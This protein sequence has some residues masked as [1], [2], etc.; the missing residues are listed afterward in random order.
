VHVTG[1]EFDLAWRG[2]EQ[3]LDLHLRKGSVVVEGPLAAGGVK[4]DAGQRL[5]ANTKLG[6]LSLVDELNVPSVEAP[7]SSAASTRTA[8]PAGAAQASPSRVALTPPA[9]VVL[10]VEDPT[11]TA[12]VAHGEFDAVIEDAERRGF[13]KA[14]AE[15][16]A[17]DLAA[18]G[19]AARYARRH[20]VAKR[21]LM[22]ER[23]RYPDSVQARDA[24]FFLG[25]IAEAEKNDAASVEWYEIYLRESPNGEYAS[26]A[27][28]RKMVLAQR[29]RDIQGAR[30]IATTYLARFPD[31]P[32]ASP[33][34]KL[35]QAQ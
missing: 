25:S 11:W 34:R 31:G 3:T 1:T 21:A 6:S 7:S 14:L 12:R 16:S 8:P 19:D 23:T 33:A 30:T 35:L 18:L 15:S 27:L 28:G 22:T 9:R 32:Y 20:D 10:K 29:M 24:P 2:E 13:D 17:L 26:Q 5:V 4:V